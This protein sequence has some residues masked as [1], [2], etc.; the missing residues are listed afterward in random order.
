MHTNGRHAHSLDGPM[1][2]W[3]ALAEAGAGSGRLGHDSSFQATA[4]ERGRFCAGKMV[5]LLPKR[6]G[7]QRRTHAY[8]LWTDLRRAADCYDECSSCADGSVDE[9]R[10]ACK[11]RNRKAVQLHRSGF[12]GTPCEGLTTLLAC[13]RVL[14]AGL[15]S[16]TP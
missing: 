2:D 15:V 13:A 3:L 10:R 6:W 8:N 14:H 7:R 12:P 16:T 9:T 1:L 4:V 5:G 11:G